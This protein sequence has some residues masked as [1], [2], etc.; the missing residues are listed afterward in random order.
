MLIAE[1]PRSEAKDSDL[2][3]LEPT[4]ALEENNIL[5]DL[6][7]HVEYEMQSKRNPSLEPDLDLGTVSEGPRIA[8]ANSPS[9]NCDQKSH[10]STVTF[11]ADRLPVGCQ[12][13]DEMVLEA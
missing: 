5:D 7:E 3:G 10:L 4:V 11:S 8:N 12:S 2:L 9:L 1:E 6:L 13:E